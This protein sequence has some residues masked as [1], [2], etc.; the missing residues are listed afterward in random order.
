MIKKILLISIVSISLYGGVTGCKYKE[1]LIKVNIVS[2]KAKF[3]MDNHCANV[4]SPASWKRIKKD[5]TNTLIQSPHKGEDNNKY[6]IKTNELQKEINKAELEEKIKKE[7]MKERSKKHDFKT[8]MKYGDLM[9]QD[10]LLNETQKMSIKKARSYCKNLNYK[11]SKNWRLPSI[12]EMQKI[13][14]VW[15]KNKPYKALKHIQL[16]YY[17]SSAHDTHFSFGSGASFRSL[18]EPAFVRCVT[19]RQ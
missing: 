12:Q 13:H 14:D 19:Q 16:S 2:N 5:K 1:D 6:W 3:M 8:V 11:G 17:W 10:S 9:W 15:G 4:Q 7:K 18:G